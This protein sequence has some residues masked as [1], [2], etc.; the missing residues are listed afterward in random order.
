MYV[1][2]KQ[3]SEVSHPPS[4]AIP[5]VPPTPYPGHDVASD[6]DDEQE[7]AKPT[8]LNPKL[9]EYF[10]LAYEEMGNHF[11]NE[12]GKRFIPVGKRFIPAKRAS[13]GHC[14][15][16]IKTK[17]VPLFFKHR[18]ISSLFIEDEDL[19]LTKD[20][21]NKRVSIFSFSLKSLSCPEDVFSSQ[22]DKLLK[23]Y[24]QEHVFSERD[25]W[26]RN[27]DQ[28]PFDVKTSDIG[29]VMI[30]LWH[31]DVGIIAA[32]RP[33]VLSD[34]CYPGDDVESMGIHEYA[35]ITY[36]IPSL[37]NEVTGETRKLEGDVYALSPCLRTRRLTKEIK[38]KIG[39]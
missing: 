22:D 6:R 14:E 33:L 18:L 15:Y 30:T 32:N 27:R 2:T 24:I 13:G 39:L 35:H 28:N 36:H 3:P 19:F 21:P 1:P 37:R 34:P 17:G 7:G 10:S 5:S 16:T 29:N 31:Y 8:G 23:T 25:S 38:A 4:F 12:V 26:R 9:S 20:S 11:I